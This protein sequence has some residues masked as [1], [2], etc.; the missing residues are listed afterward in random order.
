MKKIFF[1]LMFFL[2]VFSVNA[3]SDYSN[4]TF[5][6][7]LSFPYMWHDYKS[8]DMDA[9]TLHGIGL[10]LNYRNM[11]D[12]MKIGL[13]VN[14]DIFMPLS[15]TIAVDENT[16]TTTYLKDYDYFFGLDM[17]VGIYTV[18]FKN[19]DINIPAGL[20]FNL[21]GFIS[22]QKYGDT[23]VNESVYTL[24]VGLW[25]NVEINISKNMGVYFGSKFVYDFYHKLSNK[26]VVTTNHDGL[27]NCFSVIPAMGVLWHF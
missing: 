15:K 19:G 26:A 27:S 11:N 21:D 5:C 24:G 4:K 23:I 14:A 12:N 6:L 10:N 16:M 13:L 22:K 18:F 20:G 7:G 8:E 3:M 25:A 2:C 9:V 1:A 17:L